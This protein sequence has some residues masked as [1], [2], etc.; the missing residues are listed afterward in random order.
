MWRKV[1]SVP[2][3]FLLLLLVAC[4]APTPTITTPTSQPVSGPDSD[5]IK[6]V[7]VQALSQPAWNNEGEHSEDLLVT[8]RSSRAL[9]KEGESAQINASVNNL[10]GNPLP[11]NLILQL[12]NG[13]ILS[14]AT[15]CTG[16]PCT[17]RF[18]VLPGQ[19]ALMSVLIQ[20]SGPVAQS[21]SV[22]LHYSYPDAK[23]GTLIRSE[24]EG[25]IS[26][27]EYVVARVPNSDPTFNAVVVPP[28]TP[29]PAEQP[30]DDV[31]VVVRVPNSDSTFN[32][33]VVP[34]LAPLP[35][36]QPKDDV[37]LV[38]HWKFD[39]PSGAIA[40]DSSEYGHHGSTVG[41]PER[42]PGKFDEALSLDGVTDY[43]TIPDMP[44]LRLS[45]TQTVSTWYK[46]GEGGS[47][48]WRRLVGKGDY[49]NR[50]Y[51]LWIRP[52]MNWILFQIYSQGRKGCEVGNRTVASDANWHHLAG[53]Y[54]GSTFRIY[55]DGELV[56]IKACAITPSNTNHP[57]TIGFAS[58]KWEDPDN[59]Q[60]DGLIDDVKIYNRVLSDCEVASLARRR[61]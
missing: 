22:V 6:S 35:A 53:T 54:D 34:P 50:N 38:G 32:A 25:L 40:L 4:A 26:A 24:V 31:D 41:T 56:G 49:W 36:E 1:V 9:I 29:L 43:V 20:S 33:V 13:L 14:S 19:Q 37:D 7:E 48:N 57:V 21:Y 5:S 15:S 58:G 47:N 59:I 42:V 44:S 27:T 46:W 8:L 3:L 11:V 12:G 61:C 10:S 28:L 55:L 60:F 45:S 18:D 52:E 16:D 30:K 23:T 51:G 39:E 17:G 2:Y